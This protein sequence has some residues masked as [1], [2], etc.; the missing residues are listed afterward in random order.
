MAT[1]NDTTIL[2]LL[3]CTPFAAESDP[4]GMIMTPLMETGSLD[5]VLEQ[6]RSDNAPDWWNSTTKLKILLGTAV[7]VKVLGDHR[8]LHRNLTP[9]SILLDRNREPKLCGFGLATHIPGGVSSEHAKGTGAHPYLAP[10][11][12]RGEIYG[13][14]S[15]VFSFGFLIYSIWTGQPPFSAAPG[16]PLNPVQVCNNIASGKRPQFPADAPGPLVSLAKSCWD[17]NPKARP[18]IGQVVEALQTANLLETIPDLSER[19]FREYRDE[20]LLF[21]RLGSIRAKSGD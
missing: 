21:D 6:V 14:K 20:L 13:F 2:P 11:I 7:A 18:Q 3:G 4:K 10:E 16:H 1:V 9:Q 17:G 15:D 12:I 19:D 5:V 8:L